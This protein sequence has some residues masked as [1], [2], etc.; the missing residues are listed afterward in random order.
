MI[1]K[2]KHLLKDKVNLFSQ[3]QNELFGEKFK[4]FSYE[5]LKKKQKY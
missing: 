5:T 4:N 2:Q 1:I 3:K